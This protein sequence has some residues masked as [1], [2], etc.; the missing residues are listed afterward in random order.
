MEEECLV[1]NKHTVIYRHFDNILIILFRKVEMG[2]KSFFSSKLILLGYTVNDETKTPE[3]P[4]F[5]TT[6][7]LS[8][9]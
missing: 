6:K 8:Q 3:S 2:S 1:L 9:N 7:A 4:Y 5:F